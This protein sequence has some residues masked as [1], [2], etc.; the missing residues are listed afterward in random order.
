MCTPC[1]EFTQHAVTFPEALRIVELVE[2]KIKEREHDKRIQ[3][4]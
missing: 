3:E 1:G 4:A 2:A